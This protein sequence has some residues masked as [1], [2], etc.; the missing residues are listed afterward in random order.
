MLVLETIAKSIH[1]TATD[2]D[3]HLVLS[4][5]IQFHQ[6]LVY[7]WPS[8]H[9]YW[10]QSKSESTLLS[11][12]VN[13]THAQCDYVNPGCLLNNCAPSLVAFHHRKKEMQSVV[14]MESGFLWPKSLFCHLVLESKRTDRSAEWAPIGLIKLFRHELFP[15]PP[16]ALQGLRQET[17]SWFVHPGLN[18]RK[19]TVNR[20]HLLRDGSKWYISYHC[21]EPFSI[22]SPLR[23]Q[24]ATNQQ[25]SQ[26]NT[27]VPLEVQLLP[28]LNLLPKLCRFNRSSRCSSLI[29]PSSV[30]HEML[31]LE[32]A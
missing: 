31:F 1:W 15:V 32:H 28:E 23:K 12:K 17:W 7:F 30:V 2:I 19:Q 14:T 9:L 25:S 4:I 18:G 3:E 20:S 24:C 11:H 10:P 26:H 22:Q 8:F 27:T 5:K 13:I 29:L 21:V 16:E 6:T